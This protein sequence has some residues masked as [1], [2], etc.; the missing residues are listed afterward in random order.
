[1]QLKRSAASVIGCGKIRANELVSAALV[2]KATRRRVALQS[3]RKNEAALSTVSHE[4]AFGVR[5]VLAPLLMQRWLFTKWR[6]HVDRSE[7]SFYFCW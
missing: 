6:C 7:T 5:G 4:S 2:L 3:W 1:M